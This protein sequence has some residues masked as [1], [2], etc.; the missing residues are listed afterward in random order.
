ML[1]NWLPKLK[2]AAV[3]RFSGTMERTKPF[4]YLSIFMR[5]YE[6]TT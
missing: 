3:M 4:L 5:V 2:V 6:V 1:F